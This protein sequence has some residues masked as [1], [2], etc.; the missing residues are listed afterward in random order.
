LDN[1]RRLAKPFSPGVARFAAAKVRKIWHTAKF[2]PIISL[3]AG[4][5][6]SYPSVPAGICRR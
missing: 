4:N 2:L 6:S 1:A 5:N 3:S